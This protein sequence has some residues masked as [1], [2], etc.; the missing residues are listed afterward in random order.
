MEGSLSYFITAMGVPSVT[1]IAIVLVDRMISM[2]F[3]LVLG[4]IFS[5]LSF[6]ALKGA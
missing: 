4:F 3:A 1:A 2:Y 6:D 5:K